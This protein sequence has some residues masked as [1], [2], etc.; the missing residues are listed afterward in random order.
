[1]FIG[2]SEGIIVRTFRVYTPILWADEVND[3]VGIV[4][5]ESSR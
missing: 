2:V 5:L 4:D 3:V 1:L